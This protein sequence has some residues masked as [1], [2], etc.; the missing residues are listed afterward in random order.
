MV[1][2]KVKWNKVTLEKVELNV[3]LGVSAF[4]DTL[5]ELTGVPKDR[6]KLMAKGCWTGTLK[7]DADLSS[8]KISENQI[9]M[10]MGTADV[11]VKPKEAVAFIEDMT[12]EE[13][14]Q[15]GAAIPAGF[16]NMGNT[17]YLNATIECLR[18]MPEFRE[19]LTAITNQ[20]IVSLLRD[21]FD[22]LDRTGKSNP[23]SFAFV[24]FLTAFRAAFPQFGEV[25]RQGYSVQQDAEEFFNSLITAVKNEV[26]PQKFNSLLGLELEEE[27]R[28]EECEAEGIHYN[29]ET[30][31]KL[32]C[33]IQGGVGS[34]ILIDHLNEGLKLGLEGQLE[35]HSSILN[36]NA[37]WRKTQKISSLPRYLCIQFMRFFWKETPES[38]DHQGVKCKILRAVTTPE[39]FYLKQFVLIFSKKKS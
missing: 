26:E 36:R 14:A 31:F 32:V 3:S 22:E 28:C 4:K 5:Y 29:R 9:I 20:N 15:K 13:I 7:D 34:K 19:S 27:V 6:Q 18:H 17:C 24:R 1:L 25:N 10:L 39:V 30:V 38:L 12:I 11:I 8:Y 16:I 2:I 21:S 33:N 35:K 37:L 23:P